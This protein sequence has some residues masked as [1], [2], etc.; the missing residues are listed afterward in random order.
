MEHIIR[1]IKYEQDHKKRT[2]VSK[3]RPLVVE[4][5]KLPHEVLSCQENTD[6]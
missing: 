5:K 3:K 2:I 6:T 4:L 1:A